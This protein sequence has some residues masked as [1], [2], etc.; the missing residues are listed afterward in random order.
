MLGKDSQC[1]KQIPILYQKHL[2]KLPSLVSEALKIFWTKIFLGWSPER[3]I[4]LF[5]YSWQMKPDSQYNL[6]RVN[7]N[8]SNRYKQIILSHFFTLLYFL[9]L[10]F[11]STLFFNIVIFFGFVNFV[12]WYFSI[13]FKFIVMDLFV[14]W[15]T[16]LT[17]YQSPFLSYLI[18]RISFWEFRIVIFV[19]SFNIYLEISIGSVLRHP[20]LLLCMAASTSN[21]ENYIIVTEWLKHGTL[22]QTLQDNSFSVTWWAWMKNLFYKFVDFFFD[23]S[24]CRSFSGIGIPTPN[25]Q[26]RKFVRL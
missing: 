15:L 7:Q 21:N 10:R 19:N 2:Q 4:N 22:Q 9:L 18:L 6:K 5:L 16:L 13:W 3:S 25:N 23:C 17:F 12:L 20:N 1:G 8:F 26:L 24:D 11:F 14:L